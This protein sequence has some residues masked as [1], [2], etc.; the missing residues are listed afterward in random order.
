M[1]GAEFACYKVLKYIEKWPV[2]TW[3]WSEEPEGGG[4]GSDCLFLLGWLV[5]NKPTNALPK[6]EIFCSRL[7]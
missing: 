6:T 2:L 1:I 7:L 5:N 4:I 3:F